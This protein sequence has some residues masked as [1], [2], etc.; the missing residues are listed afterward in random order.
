[1]KYPKPKTAGEIVGA[2]LEQT[3]R[4]ELSPRQR[5]RVKKAANR[6]MREAR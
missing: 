4:R 6:A 2:F 3:G 1:M 5:R